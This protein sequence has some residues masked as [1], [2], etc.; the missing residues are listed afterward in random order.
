MDNMRTVKVVKR[1][2]PQGCSNPCTTEEIVTGKFHQWGSSYEE[3]EGGPGNF[4]IAIVEM[5]DG[6]IITPQPED[7]VF[8]D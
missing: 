2:W 3:F 1:Y 4:T 8:Q 5:P 6:S 7:I